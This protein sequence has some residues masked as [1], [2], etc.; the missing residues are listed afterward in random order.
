M[1]G[2]CGY[3]MSNNAVAAYDNGLRPASKIPG[4]PAALVREFCGSDEWHHSS[5][6]Y[7]K[8]FF[9]DPT[10]VRAKF[11]LEVNEEY[12]SNPEAVAA[13]ANH[14]SARKTG[15]TIYKNCSVEW[16]EW[17]GSMKHPTCTKRSADGC[18]ITIKGQTA[19]ITLPGGEKLTK[20]L[21]TRGFYYKTEE[22]KEG[23]E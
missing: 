21:S 1:A 19:T 15:G 22:E 5:K 12:E 23:D 6:A 4:V 14:K 17:T 10:Y 16:L 7:N 11:G 9:Y 2:Y 8:V 20:R 18:A 3:S 13:L